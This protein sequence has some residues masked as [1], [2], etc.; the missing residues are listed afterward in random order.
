[1]VAHEEMCNGIFVYRI[2]RRTLLVYRR[3]SC[4]FKNIV[5]LYI[6]ESIKIIVTCY[7]ATYSSQGTPYCSQG[8]PCSSQGTP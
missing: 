5:M 2:M 3:V 7:D 6:T 1:M 4:H 8:T